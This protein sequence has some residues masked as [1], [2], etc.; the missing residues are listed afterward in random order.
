VKI[1]A[2]GG[3]LS[4]SKVV[5]GTGYNALSDARGISAVDAGGDNG[6]FAVR[7]S[8]LLVSSA[9]ADGI[10]STGGTNHTAV[11]TNNIITGTAGGIV[12]FATGANELTITGNT[13]R[14]SST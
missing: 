13:I 6:T 3:T 12:S 4:N 2:G 1:G 11:F 7:D 10:L 14:V 8:S 5:A 9:N